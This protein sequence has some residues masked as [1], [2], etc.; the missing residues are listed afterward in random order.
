M[1]MDARDR[2]IWKAV[3]GGAFPPL[4]NIWRF[5]DSLRW[6]DD[7]MANRGLSYSDIKYPT[8]TSSYG[9]MSSSVNYVSSNIRRLYT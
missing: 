6:M 4:N 2:Y 9:V 8:L 5:Q 7:Y 3:V 1:P